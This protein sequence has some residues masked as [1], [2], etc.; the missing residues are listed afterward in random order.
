[1]YTRAPRQELHSVDHGC[2]NAR[3]A[4]TP[5]IATHCQAMR[6]VGSVLASAGTC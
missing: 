2:S 4:G 3:L 5:A 6:I 1:M